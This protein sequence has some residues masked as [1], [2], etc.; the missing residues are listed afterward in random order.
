LDTL[1][2]FSRPKSMAIGL[3]PQTDGAV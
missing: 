2:G 3:Q 1:A